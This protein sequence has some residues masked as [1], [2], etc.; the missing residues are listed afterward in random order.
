MSNSKTG[1]TFNI[2]SDMAGHTFKSLLPSIK[3]LAKD[4]HFTNMNIIFN[5][6][7]EVKYIYEN[8]YEID[9]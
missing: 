4:K 3:T 1:E 9:Y 7:Q 5:G 8:S 2:A 6:I